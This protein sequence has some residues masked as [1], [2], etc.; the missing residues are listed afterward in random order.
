MPQI[1]G[2]NIDADWHISA[3][4][5]GS[6]C[7]DGIEDFISL[8][9]CL[10]CNEAGYLGTMNQAGYTFKR[11][12][13]KVDHWAAP[14]V[15]DDDV[16]MRWTHPEKKVETVIDLRTIFSS[17]EYGNMSL[18]PVP[19]VV[20]VPNK[21]EDEQKIHSAFLAQLKEH[22]TLFHQP[23]DPIIEY[24]IDV[25][26]GKNWALFH[27]KAASE[28]EGHVFKT[29]TAEAQA[30]VLKIAD[31]TG[32]KYT[33]IDFSVLQGKIAAEWG[34]WI[35]GDAEFNLVSG[36]VGVFDFKAGVG[37]ATGVGFRDES[38][39]VELSGCGFIIGKRVGVSA[40]GTEVS[41]N[42]GRF[43]PN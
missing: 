14:T 5:M 25:D 15:D 18:R 43:F 30:S 40:L 16:T 17:D 11:I 41:I 24:A 26:H 9:D 20:F 8:P 2:F 19:V 13:L 10:G 12:D 36:R 4:C 35:G 22:L 34:T 6:G 37:A 27:V 33:K 31:D 28:T 32:K 1:W 29:F 21:T 7:P 3:T 23:E 39:E 38:A 42:F